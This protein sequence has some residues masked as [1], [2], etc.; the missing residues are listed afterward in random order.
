MHAGFL[1]RI[2]LLRVSAERLEIVEMKAKSVASAD[3]AHEDN[4]ILGKA[5]AERGTAARKIL[6]EWVPYLQDLAFQKVLLERWLVERG[7]EV[8]LLPG[9]PVVPGMILVNKRGR[10]QA[11]DVLRNFSTRHAADGTA[12]RATVSYVGPGC[13]DTQILVEM[14]GIPEIVGRMEAH[15]MAGDPALAHRGIGDCMDRMLAIVREDAWPAAATR[16]GVGCKR[17]EFRTPGS[18]PSGFEECWGAIRVRHHVLTLPRVTGEQ[19]KSALA[20]SPSQSASAADV[21]GEDITSSQR[22]AWTCLQITGEPAPIVSP[23][24][25]SP[26]GRAALLRTESPHDPCHFVDFE[27]GMYPIPQRVGGQP[28]EWIPFQFEAHTLPSADADLRRRVRLEGFLDLRSD[29]P[30]ANFVRQLR[31]QLGDHGVVYHWHRYEATVLAKLRNAFTAGDGVTAG[32]APELVAFIDSLL[33]D[34]EDGRPG[35]LCDLMNV[36]KDAFY[37]PDMLGSYSIKKV[38]PVVWRRPEIRSHFWPGHGCPGDPDAYGHAEDPY[39]AL[40]TLPAPFLEAVGGAEALRDLERAAEESAP[41]LPETL[42]NGGS[43]MLLYHYVRGFGGG[44]RQD[45]RALF[46]NYCGL[47]SAAMV[48]VFRY[49]NEVVPTFE[50]DGDAF[51]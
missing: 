28:Y 17:C 9:T 51:P 36:A 6:S 13:P 4:G 25:K 22:P 46:R 34:E 5:D 31:R 11:G 16:L 32:D 10:A 41:G 29:D 24:F 39:L 21:P 30:R 20:A 12:P 44:D 1:A 47:D 45:V 8:G 19:V 50:G 35:R 43:A 49:M 15:A 38:L 23:R 37:H 33:G 2:D 7:Q 42:R 14:T 27:C 18:A 3:A 26:E 40:P 48:M